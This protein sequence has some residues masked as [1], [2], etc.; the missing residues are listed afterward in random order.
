MKFFTRLAVL[1]YVSLIMVFCCALLL[2]SLNLINYSG[3]SKLIFIS[4]YDENMKMG[5][6]I[7]AG[8]LLFMNFIIYRFFSVNIHKD[9]IIAFDNPSGRVSV[10]LFALEDLLRRMLAKISEI[11][12][13]RSSIKA[14]RKGLKV[15]IKLTLCSDVNIPEI[16]SKVQSMVKGK[17]QDTVGIEED[18]DIAIFVGKIIPQKIKEIKREGKEEENINQNVPFQGYRV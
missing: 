10:S 4:Y 7:F 11:K 16:T 2:F 3:I 8:V 9:K 12:E 17:I 13:A 5:I 18:V 6:T 1:L 14:G 15:K